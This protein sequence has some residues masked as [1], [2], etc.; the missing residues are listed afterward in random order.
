MDVYNII[1]HNADKGGF[2]V[3]I[4][5]YIHHV[6]Y[7][8]TDKMGVVHHSNFVRWMEEARVYMM[9]EAG[10]GYGRLEKEGIISP[11]I[12]VKCDY[13]IMA[14][15]EDDIL[16]ETDIKEYNGI[17]LV[18]EYVMENSVTEK[19]VAKGQSSHCFLNSSGRPVNLKKVCPELDKAFNLLME[20]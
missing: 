13:K 16:I 10:F 18:I 6:Q 8:E 3:N 5:P 4:K 9:A 14:Q 15:F 1:K 12:G 17:K 19:I 20:K 2:N 11:V 7:Y